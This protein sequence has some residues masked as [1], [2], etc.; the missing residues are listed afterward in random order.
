MTFR[1][2]IA[3]RQEFLLSRNGAYSLH[4]YFNLDLKVESIK[5]ILLLLSQLETRQDLLTFEASLANQ[6]TIRRYVDSNYAN[7]LLE[8]REMNNSLSQLVV[9]RIL[10]NYRKYCR[11]LAPLKSEW[12]LASVYNVDS[13]LF[14]PDESFNSR[15]VDDELLVSNSS[16][17]K[18]YISYTDFKSGQSYQHLTGNLTDS[19]H[20]N[21]KLLVSKDHQQYYIFTERLRIIQERV[22]EFQT[23]NCPFYA[24]AGEF[25][26]T[27]NNRVVVSSWIFG[28]QGN[29]RLN[30]RDIYIDHELISSHVGETSFQI[31]MS[32]I[33]SIG[34]SR[35]YRYISYWSWRRPAC[36]T[37]NFIVAN[38][39]DYRRDKQKAKKYNRKMK[40]EQSKQPT[41]KVIVLT[42]KLHLK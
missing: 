18:Y 17:I 33:E 29:N 12:L 13:D 19:L 11:D 4:R 40:G 6:K 24:T 36:Q 26:V 1:R 37:D 2:I 39:K 34:V 16:E 10:R 14:E 8:H 28:K 42:K 3:E 9:V 22:L 31:L 23:I 41:V 32:Y 35:N 30:I 5:L 20:R 25:C 15:L 21:Q 27:S 7:W 38:L